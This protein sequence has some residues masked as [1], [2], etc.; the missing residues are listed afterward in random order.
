VDGAQAT[1][2]WVRRAIYGIQIKPV[3]GAFLKVLMGFYKRAELMLKAERK[4]V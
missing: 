1:F 3:F 4:E 2:L